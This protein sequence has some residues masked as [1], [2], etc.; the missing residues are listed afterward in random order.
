MSGRGWRI[1]LLIVALAALGGLPAADAAERVA[2]VIGN[3]TYAHAPRLNATE[4]DAKEMAKVLTELGFR[5]TGPLLDQSKTEME[6]AL[7]DF[8]EQARGAAAAVVY[9]SG[10]GMEVGGVN[11]L[12]PVT[13]KLQHESRAPLEAVPLDVVLTQVGGAR[14]YGL[15]ILD[16]C[17]DNP[18]ANQMRLADGRTKDWVGK[19]L[20]PVEPSGQVYVAYA[21]KGGTK[22]QEGRGPNSRFTTALLN[23]LRNYRQDPLPLS[24]L[25]GAVRED[26]LAATTKTQEP[27]LYGAFGR[28]SIYLIDEL[29]PDPTPTST[30]VATAGVP[31]PFRPPVPEEVP[32]E[33]SRPQPGQVFRDTLS[34][35]TRGPALVVIGAGEFW[36]GSPESEAGREPDK[37]AGR[38]QRHRVEIGRAFALGQTE[39]TVGEFRRFVEAA[40]YRTDAEKNAGGV[41]G[42]FVAYREGSEWKYGY[43]AGYGWKNPGFKQ[44]DDHPVVCVSW[45]DA[46]AY[47]QWLSQQ[48]GQKYRLPSEAEWEYA[49]RAG[50]TGA[51][52]WG[53]DPNRACGYAN[54]ADRTAKQ[55]FSDWTIHD[56]RDGYVYTAPVGTFQAN[57]WKLNDMLGNVWEWTCSAYAEEYDGSE[58]RCADQETT[59]PLAVRGG[60]WNNSPAWVRS[61]SRNR[62]T[63]ALRSNARGFRLARS[64]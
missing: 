45:R 54:V 30:P 55:T 46:M 58:S 28:K 26:V 15:V 37:E 23:Y 31:S 60:A 57:A 9:F 38:E 36:M 53:E 24:N 35:G 21:A 44:G 5:V 4:R 14:D 39:V 6:T 48:T 64:L 33:G 19:G 40:G 59:G 12:I 43:R 47:S 34:D 42:C 41:E 7:G 29:P 3:G 25:F 20:K 61:A 17:R 10:H 49:A 52:Y 51:R 8:G 1:G 62:S 16:A 11:Y 63:P 22:A 27:W 32:P 18:L 56:C 13:A 50:T 2:L